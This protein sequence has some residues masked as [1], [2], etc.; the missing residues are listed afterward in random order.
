MGKNIAECLFMMLCSSAYL[1]YTK[2]QSIPYTLSN[3]K[4]IIL[5]KS[6]TI[7]RL[8][9]GIYHSMKHITKKTI[10][11]HCLSFRGL[12]IPWSSWLPNHT[13]HIWTLVTISLKNVQVISIEKPWSSVMS[14]TCKHNTLSN[15]QINR[16]S[17]E[18]LFQRREYKSR[19]GRWKI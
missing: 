6:I 15:Y 18:S 5:E 8:G 2:H 3:G 9:V 16:Q 7:K 1:L 12:M 10:K 11:H 17:A 14:L 19:R 4:T 13:A